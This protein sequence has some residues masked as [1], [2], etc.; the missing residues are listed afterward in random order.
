M[1]RNNID[2]Y[3][4]NYYQLPVKIPWSC[5]YGLFSMITIGAAIIIGFFSAI[6][7]C[8]WMFPENVVLMNNSS[9]STLFYEMIKV[10]SPIAM[11]LVCIFRVKKTNR[12]YR[13]EK[14][15]F[16]AGDVGMVIQIIIVSC[17]KC[18]LLYCVLALIASPIAILLMILVAI[19]TVKKLLFF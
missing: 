15:K 12:E 2:L 4:S 18:A 5:G 3:D 7:Y 14:E 19:V 13:K 16:S 6:V 11:F 8:N 1:S 17:F 9:I 10:S